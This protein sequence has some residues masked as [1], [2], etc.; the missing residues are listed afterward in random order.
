MGRCTGTAMTG[1]VACL[2]GRYVNV[3]MKSLGSL[4]DRLPG[5]GKTS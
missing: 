4:A 3:T 5:R 1:R 2:V